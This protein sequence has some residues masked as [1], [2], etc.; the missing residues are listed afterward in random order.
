MAEL[1]APSRD[2]P[3]ASEYLAYEAELGCLGPVRCIVGVL[4]TRMN[5]GV[6][7]AWGEL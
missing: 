4:L 5:L 2:A 6:T 7:D 1:S 3:D